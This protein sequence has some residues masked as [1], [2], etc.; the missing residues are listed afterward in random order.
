MIITFV[1]HVVGGKKRPSLIPATGDH[2]QPSAHPP[3]SRTKKNYCTLG[4]KEIIRQIK[5]CTTSMR[6]KIESNERFD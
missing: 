5:H 2:Y 3:Q 6:L 1:L 4:T